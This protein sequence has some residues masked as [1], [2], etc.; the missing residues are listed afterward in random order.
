M[1]K[2][3]LIY[4]KDKQ[5]FEKTS[6]MMRL[7]GKPIETA[8][9]LKERGFEL[10]HIIDVD[11]QRGTETNF[12]VYDKLTYIMNIELECENEKF[13][14]RMLEMNVRFVIQLPA[15]IDLK[16]FSDKK[17]R[18]VGKLDAHYNGSVNDVYDLLIENANSE[19]VKKYS[20]L[21]RRILVYKKDFTKEM[22]KFVFG[23][24]E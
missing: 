20:T 22:E 2:A 9:K 5:F 24:I 7:I 23:V 4:L 1:I 19:S 17:R 13:M 18:L 12:D 11:A 6:G 16:K 8:K 14:H 15:N 21:G 3:K 10:I